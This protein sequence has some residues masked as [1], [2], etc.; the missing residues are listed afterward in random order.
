M[1]IVLIALLFPFTLSAQNLGLPNNTGTKLMTQD[2]RD[3]VV[4][5]VMAHVFV[6]SKGQDLILKLEVRGLGFEK[7][8]WVQDL[9]HH[10]TQPLDFVS[11]ISDL[12]KSGSSAFW[13]TNPAPGVENI[14]LKIS[15]VEIVNSN[16]TIE[17]HGFTIYVKSDGQQFE[18]HD[19]RVYR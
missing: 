11:T 12:Q 15:N 6:H 5:V 17:P 1:R 13:L 10:F 19:I 14:L 4:K 18:N 9:V 7:E 16:G 3:G 2:S 8:I